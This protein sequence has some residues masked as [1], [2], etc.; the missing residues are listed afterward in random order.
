M[1]KELNGKAEFLLLATPIL[2]FTII[3]AGSIQRPDLLYDYIIGYVPLSI[4]FLKYG[5]LSEKSSLIT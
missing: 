2:F 5:I 3:V 1:N 4:M